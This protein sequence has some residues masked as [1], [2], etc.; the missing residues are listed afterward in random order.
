MLSVQES[1]A[2]YMGKDVR[3]SVATARI[4]LV[5]DDYTNQQN[6]DEYLVYCGYQVLC[7]GNGFGLF[8]ALVDF[9]PHLIWLDLKLPDID[10]FTL[11]GQLQKSPDWGHIPVI[12]VSALASKTDQQRA[13]SLGAVQYLVKP[14]KLD[15][16]QQ[17]IQKVLPNYID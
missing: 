15:A 7:L 4:L 17:A 11:L 13:R 16:L 1:P 10:G 5:E 9:Q 12:V 8:E 6:F 2:A 3:A 14:V